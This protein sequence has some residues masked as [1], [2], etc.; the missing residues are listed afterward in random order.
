[1]HIDFSKFS[2]EVQAKIKAAL[3]DKTSPGKIDLA[4]VEKMGLSKKEVCPL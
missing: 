3:V 2:Q 4:E 1:M